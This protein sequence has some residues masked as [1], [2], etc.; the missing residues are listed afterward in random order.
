[1]EEN[2]SVLTVAEIAA[3]TRISKMTIYR[4]VHSGALPSFRVGKSFR[5][6]ETDL[7]NYIALRMTGLTERGN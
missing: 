4:E 5:V 6:F 7:V 3:K 2:I 1:M